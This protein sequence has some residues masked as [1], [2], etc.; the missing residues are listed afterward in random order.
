MLW[1]T[2]SIRLG[3]LDWVSRLP[4]TLAILQSFDIG[5]MFMP[6]P[7]NGSKPY[8]GPP[9]TCL[10]SADLLILR[11]LLLRDPFRVSPS[12]SFVTYHVYTSPCV[13]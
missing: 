7:L 13:H 11:P 8:H 5:D 12:T 6:T 4:T 9:N 2:T 10:S 1:F 3:L